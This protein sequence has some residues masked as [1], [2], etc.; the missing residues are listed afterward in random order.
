MDIL[1][2]FLDFEKRKSTLLS[3]AKA[4][5]TKIINVFSLRI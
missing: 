4:R 2:L 5:T 3:V 1:P